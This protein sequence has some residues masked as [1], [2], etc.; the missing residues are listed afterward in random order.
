MTNE[1]ILDP[2]AVL[3]MELRAS[4][5]H[6]NIEIQSQRVLIANLRA[7]LMNCQRFL[8]IIKSKTPHISQRF[9]DE[10]PPVFGTVGTDPETG[11]MVI[12]AT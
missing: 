11:H 12:I 1:R 2:Q 4:L 6:R 7:E 8:G 5:Q 10:S 3:I 9:W